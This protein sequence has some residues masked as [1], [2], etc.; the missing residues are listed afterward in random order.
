[1]LEASDVSVRAGRH[2]LLD[3]LSLALRP[4]ELTALVGPNGAGKSTLVGLLSGHRRPEHGQVA[5]DGRP[6][7]GWEP[8]ALAR[9]RAVLTQD[10]D[11]GF[12]FTVREV[13][14]LG[15]APHRGRHGRDAERAVVERAME[16]A[17]VAHL[18]GRSYPSLSGGERQRAMLARVLAQL[19]E[20]EGGSLAGRWLLLDE[21]T[22]SLDLA[23]Q[24]LVLEA[25]AGLTR[26]GCGAVVVL[27]DLNLAARFADRVAMLCRGRLVAFGTPE[28]VL[29][30]ARVSLIYAV[31]V[32]RLDLGGR[33]CLTIA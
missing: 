20:P 12:A 14:A 33:P 5:L 1:M 6:I 4:G 18:A 25:V 8:Q 15:R 30:A 22:A 19:L 16:L 2:L 24:K 7:A 28:E 9:R 32:A 29:T 21:P 31:E 23:H 17:Q 13:V 11:L 26:Q 10:S 3:A 27:H